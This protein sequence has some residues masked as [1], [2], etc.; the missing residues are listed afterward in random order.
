MV[1]DWMECM[2]QVLLRS[3]S[4]PRSTYGSELH[5]RIFQMRE[6]FTDE[7]I[8]QS[9][10]GKTGG[11]CDLLVKEEGGAVRLAAAPGLG[12]LSATVK[13]HTL[14]LQLRAKV[15]V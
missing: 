13:G 12:V 2:G 1:S 8:I 11:L 14:A 6:R 5:E 3:K 10:P 4:S 7:S 15:L 9:S